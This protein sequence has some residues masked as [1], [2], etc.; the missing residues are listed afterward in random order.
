MYRDLGR[1]RSTRRSSDFELEFEEPALVTLGF[2]YEKRGRLA[3]GA[4]HSALR[5]VD[6]WVDQSLAKAATRARA[7][8][9]AA[10]SSSTTR[11]TRAVKKLKERGLTSPYLKSFVVARINPLRFIKGDLPSFDELFATMTK[12]AKGFDAEQDKDRG[13]GPKRR[14]PG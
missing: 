1:V 12:R 6:A 3:G 4:Y 2:A 13:P 9:G 5:K 8:R 11:S 14:R 10:C 7:P